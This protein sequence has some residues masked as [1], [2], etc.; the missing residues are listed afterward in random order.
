MNKVCIFCNKKTK[1]SSY[2]TPYCLACASFVWYFYFE[3][4]DNKIITTI[5]PYGKK[6]W[7]KKNREHCP[8]PL[9]TEE[10][11]QEI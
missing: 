11:L 3:K 8:Y 10:K 5:T 2:C 7:E 6:A 4:I 1:T 9:M